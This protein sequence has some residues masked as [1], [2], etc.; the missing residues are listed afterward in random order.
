MKED[1]LLSVSMVLTPFFFIGVLKFNSHWR[2]DRVAEVQTIG[3]PILLWL[4][5]AMRIWFMHRH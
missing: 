4:V 2:F 3:G 5:T 1:D